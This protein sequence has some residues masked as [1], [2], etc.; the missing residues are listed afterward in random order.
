MRKI[1]VMVDKTSYTDKPT[2]YDVAGIQNRLKNSSTI[3]EVDPLYL[4]HYATNGY[5]IRPS[6]LKDGAS[7]KDFQ[8]QEII[9]IDI[10]NKKGKPVISLKEILLKL[11]NYGL[12]AFGYYYTFSHCEE[13]PRFRIIFILDKPITD[14]NEMDFI[15]KVLNNILPNADTSCASVAKLYYGTNGEAHILD[16][17]AE[18]TFEDIV[19]IS[20]EFVIDD[21]KISI[22]NHSNN[23][24]MPLLYS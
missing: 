14:I 5:T 19:R 15:L 2:Q 17:D 23:H 16:H 3:E 6:I 7:E 22:S 10:D 21:K 1:K 9:Y 24:K 4:I 20:E 11:N 13:Y 12:N 18:I 8:Q